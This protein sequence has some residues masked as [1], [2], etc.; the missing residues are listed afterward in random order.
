MHVTI[1]SANGASAQ[2]TGVLRAV[3]SL[4]AGGIADRPSLI[5]LSFAL[6][7]PLSVEC[8]PPWVE[9]LV[10]SHPR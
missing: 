1:L 9:G 5:G 4:E 2:L 10:V 7:L 6:R 8:T 3:D